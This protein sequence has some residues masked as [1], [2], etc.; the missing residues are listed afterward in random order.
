MLK[1]INGKYHK[2]YTGFVLINLKEA[3]TGRKVV[4]TEVKIKHLTESEIEWYLNSSEP[5]DKAGAYAIQ[6]I[7]SFLVEK[8]SGSYTNVVG[9][10]LAEVVEAFKKYNAY[11]IF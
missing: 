1:L 10:P 8:I 6:G 2:V 11:S 9:L 7:G 4:E 3:R 5:F